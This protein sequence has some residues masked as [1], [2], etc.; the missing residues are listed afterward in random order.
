MNKFFKTSV[1]LTL[2]TLVAANIF[3]FVSS[4]GI[5]DRITMFEMD[6]K[7]LHEENLTLEKK[8]SNLTSLE[9]ARKQAE[10]MDFTKIAAPTFLEKLGVAYQY[11]P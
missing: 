1:W 3:L 6:T 9:F 4:I 8:V 7:K 11:T 2:I 10:E 5:G